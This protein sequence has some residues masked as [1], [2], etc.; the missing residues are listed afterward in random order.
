ML[1]TNAARYTTAVDSLDALRMLRDSVTEWET[2]TVRQAREQGASWE[3]IGQAMGLRRQAVWLRY[4][5][6]QPNGS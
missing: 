3:A 5:R 4:G 1:A 2:E 6:E